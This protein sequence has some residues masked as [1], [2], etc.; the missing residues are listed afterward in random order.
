MT[1]TEAQNFQRD[2]NSAIES[3]L[4]QYNLTKTSG[5]VRFGEREVK[6]SLT[7]EQLNSNGT[8]KADEGMENWLRHEFHLNGVQN[9]PA[10]IIGSKVKSWNGKVFEI[11][12][13]NRKAHKYPIEA[14]EVS[15]GQMYKLTGNGLKFV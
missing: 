11:T 4:R 6:V 15:T 9:L 8:H 3:V 13:Y 7:L 2:L 5:G 10:Q 14:M 12:G 1:R